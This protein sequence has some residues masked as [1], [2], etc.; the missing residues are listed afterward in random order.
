MITF[1]LLLEHEI[2]DMIVGIRVVCLISNSQPPFVLS[3]P[4]A[5]FQPRTDAVPIVDK[6]NSAIIR[7]ISL[8]GG[9]EMLQRVHEISSPFQ[10]RI[11]AVAT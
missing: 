1:V 6:M 7:L 3:V 2:I 10:R 8:R 5:V 9:P 11:A 4:G